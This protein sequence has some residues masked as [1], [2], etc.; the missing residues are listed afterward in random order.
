[1]VK[2]L[3]KTSRQRI[4]T[5]TDGTTLRVGAFDG[6]KPF[7]DSLV[8]SHIKSDESAGVVSVESVSYAKEDKED[9]KSNKGG[10]K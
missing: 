1:M 8:C 3:N 10:T 4:Y 7:E 9:T 2:I 6:S 5:L